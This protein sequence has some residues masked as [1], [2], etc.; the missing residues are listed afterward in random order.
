MKESQQ[1]IIDKVE[2][3]T[4]AEVLVKYNEKKDFT[5]LEA[6]KKARL[7]KLFFY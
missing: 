5:T 2:L 3:S 4:A 7:V 6:W 1:Y